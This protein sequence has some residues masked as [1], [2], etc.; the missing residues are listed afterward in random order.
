MNEV[1]TWIYIL[2]PILIIWSTFWKA[3][4][5]WHSAR[6]ADVVWFIVFLVINSLGI[7]E[8]VYLAISGIF[9]NNQLFKK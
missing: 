6:R 7:L 9:K 5:L 8:I 4:A 1:P 2:L 3:L